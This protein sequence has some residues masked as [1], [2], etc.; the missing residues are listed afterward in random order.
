[1]KEL[2]ASKIKQA[3]EQQGYNQDEFVKTINLGWSRQTLG[4]VENSRRDVKAWELCTIAGVLH[5]DIS[6]F[7]TPIKVSGAKADPVILWRDRDDQVHKIKEAEFIKH[8]KNYKI[9]EE[10][11]PNNEKIDIYEIPRKKISLKDFTFENAMSLAQEFR[12]LLDLGDYPGTTLKKVLEEKY[13]VKFIFMDLGENG[14]AA[15]YVGE[16]GTCILINSSEVPWRQNFSIAHELFHII[17]W[18]NFLLQEVKKNKELWDKNEKLANSFAASL[19]LPKEILEKEINDI[20]T[21][22]QFT[23]ISFVVLARKFDVSLEALLWRM[24]FLHN[25]TDENRKKLQN[26]PELKNIDKMS[27]Y[28]KRNRMILISDRF[29]R[30]AFLA[31]SLGNISEMRFAEMLKI[32]IADLPSTLANYGYCELVNNE[33]QTINARC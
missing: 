25:I 30:M 19:L 32:N 28:S 9:V 5:L 7:L 18:D 1:M 11:S 23:K 2:I 24:K 16:Y 13:K 33:V 20:T 12:D 14:S 22:E 10:L 29:M 15:S 31:Y 26:D 27:L 3:R 21:K 6:H 8:C 4:E 17:T